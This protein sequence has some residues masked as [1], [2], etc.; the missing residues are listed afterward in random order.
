MLDVKIRIGSA[1]DEKPLF[2]ECS[3][4]EICTL[5]GVAILESGMESGKASVAMILETDEGEYVLAE[6]SAEILR[7]IAKV[8]EGAEQRFKSKGEH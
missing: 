2:P 6:T 7:G 1:N 8:L 5:Y 3:E 4:A